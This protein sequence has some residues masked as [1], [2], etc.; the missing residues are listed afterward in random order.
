M[1]FKNDETSLRLDITSYEFPLDN[2]EPGSDDQNWLVIRATYTDEDGQHI[3]DSN[4][5]LLTYE[6]RELT[7]GLKVLNA[8][9]RQRY[10]SDFA[11]PYFALSA[12]EEGEG[13]RV[14]VSFA[15]PNTMEDIDTAEVEAML[16][17][18]E[19]KALI[20]ELDRLCEKF[21]DRNG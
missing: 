21:P 18:E 13:F 8:G 14:D 7:V 19:M 3:K 15:L 16:T 17:K 11:E 5:C 1:L 6:L 2:G 9:I 20:A 10:D 12:A 4:A